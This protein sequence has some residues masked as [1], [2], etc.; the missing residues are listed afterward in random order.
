LRGETVPRRGLAA[1]V[2]GRLEYPGSSEIDSPE[3]T[4]QRWDLIRGKRFL[5]Q[6]YDEWYSAI[7]STIPSSPKPALELGSGAGF[8]SEH[9]NNLIT[10]DIL[11]LPGVD[12]VI[13]ASAQ[14]PFEDLS[15]RGIAMVNTLHH[16]PDVEFFFGEASRVLDDGG[17]ISMV[18]PWNT[19]WSRFV[20]GN[21][22]HEPFEPGVTSWRFE[23]TGPLS[24]ANGALPWLVFARDRQRFEQRFPALAV[25][26]VTP[27]MPIRYLLSGGVS[28]RALVPNWSYEPLRIAEQSLGRAGRQTAMFAHIVVVRR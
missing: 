10:S 7:A 6:I 3:T 14:L 19:R 4:I 26:A 21:L 13:D 5:R 23:S 12:R 22:H 28:M 17:T 1:R 9:V 11:D 8:M 20:Y 18:E 16:L 25:R 2:A 15:L 24:G 27:L